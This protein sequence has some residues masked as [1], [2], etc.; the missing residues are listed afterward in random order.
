MTAHPLKLLFDPKIA[1]GLMVL[2][3]FL[4][5]YYDSV[6]ILLGLWSGREE[7]IYRYGFLVLACSLYLLIIKREQFQH[8]EIKPAYWSLIPAALFGFAW[9]AFGLADISSLQLGVLPLILLSLVG[10]L[11]GREHIRLSAIPVLILLFAIP[12]WWPGYPILKDATTLATE[13]FLRLIDKP[14]FVEGYYLHLPGGSFF[15]DDG[16][17]GLRFLLVTLI[18]GFVTID[19]HAL[20][21]KK[22]LA[23]LGIGVGLA[24]V[25]N[26]VRVII[27]VLVGDATRMEHRW[28]TD[29]NDVGWF[30][31]GVCVLLPF[32]AFIH[33]ATNPEIESIDSQKVAAEK[34][35]QKRT[36]LPAIVL[37]VVAVVFGPMLNQLVNRQAIPLYDPVLPVAVA[38]WTNIS[39]PAQQVAGLTWQPAYSNETKRDV[40]VFAIQDEQVNLHLVNYA[41][42]SDTADLINLGNQLA[43]GEDWEALPGTSLGVQIT[44]DEAMDLSVN[45]VQLSGPG[46]ARLLVWYWFEVGAFTVSN[47]NLA[48]IYQLLSLLSGRQD[49][50]LLALAINCEGLCQPKGEI[51]EQFLQAH[52]V[53]I[54]AGVSRGL[55]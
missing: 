13:T 49:A 34:K 47:T 31:Y 19:L 21:L 3:L 2:L 18:L 44:I 24:L 51:L 6:E 5:S 9:F 4:L 40:G 45:E 48:K 42:Q 43:D 17:A 22:S 32:F 20:S 25:A 15:V 1:G 30:V 26:W 29:H 11:Y 36:V 7:T 10:L 46:N 38:P 41:V 28:V 35:I 12:L 14:V 23:L 53:A 55:P 37:S 50:N 33:Y 54:K 27:V 52:F 39:S 16:C 8:A